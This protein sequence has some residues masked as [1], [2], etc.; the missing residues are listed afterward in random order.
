M[1]NKRRGAFAVLLLTFLSPLC[2]SALPQY[3]FS[4][5]SGSKGQLGVGSTADYLSPVRLTAFKSF[6]DNATAVAAGQQH[7][8]FVSKLDFT[9]VGITLPSFSDSFE[10]QQQRG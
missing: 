6:G 10:A 1:G 8:L 4:F 5:G 7:S 9:G 2:S 3:V